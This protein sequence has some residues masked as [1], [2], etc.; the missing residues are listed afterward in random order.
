[1]AGA[2]PDAR[3]RAGWLTPGEFKT[4]ISTSRISCVTTP[5]SRTLAAVPTSTVSISDDRT[6]PVCC[7][8][9]NGGRD[10]TA[11]LVR[12]EFERVSVG[13]IPFV[14]SSTSE[15]ARWLID[16][17]AVNHTA[18]NV[19][20]AN[21]YNVALAREDPDYRS[22]LSDQ[23]LNFPDGTPIVWFMRYF[24]HR[25]THP[26]RVRGHSLFLETMR[27]SQTRGTRHFL[28]GGTPET[29]ELLRAC[30]AKSYPDLTLAGAYSPPFA[31]A[32]DAFITDCAARIRAAD[33]D[34][35]WVGLGTPKQDVVGTALA[36]LT[37]IPTVNVGA[38]FNFSAGTTPEAPEWIQRSGFEW[39]FRLLSEPRRLGKR[40]LIGNTRFLMAVAA[41]W[42]NDHH[43]VAL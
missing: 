21:A 41:R 13:G 11:H 29:L 43:P 16:D 18:I 4:I 39:L 14:V 22:L 30:L 34:I 40:Y 17:A 19:R 38:A 20:L 36:D 27:S 3:I 31:P 26:Q 9:R 2:A 8:A 25:S 10:M 1:M 6:N 12:P 23:G 32:D 7:S 5:P 37:G 35:V 24:R 33:P 15:A 28:L 42:H